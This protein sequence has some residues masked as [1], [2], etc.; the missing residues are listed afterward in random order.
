M[1]L[2]G[3]M[4]RNWCWLTPTLSRTTKTLCPDQKIVCSTWCYFLEA[5]LNLYIPS[6]APPN[7]PLCCPYTWKTIDCN[8]VIGEPLIIFQFTSLQW[9]SHKYKK[10]WSWLEKIP[11]ISTEWSSSVWWSEVFPLLS[12]PRTP[13]IHEVSVLDR[14]RQDARIRSLPADCER[15][16]CSLSPGFLPWTRTFSFY[17]Q[18]NDFTH[19]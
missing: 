9:P 19:L 18:Y 8:R 5:V 7:S 15:V 2:R 12:T 11:G 3:K 13:N 6:E 14:M 16:T 1:M 4:E 17:S 10:I